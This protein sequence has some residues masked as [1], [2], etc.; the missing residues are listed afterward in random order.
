[1]TGE[2]LMLLH[3]TEGI[4]NCDYDIANPVG[5]TTGGTD[6]ARR[7][8]CTKWQ[9][10]Y[11]PATGGYVRRCAPGGFS[12]VG[13]VGSIGSLGQA[14][15]LRGTFADVKG[16]LITAGIAAGGVLLTDKVFDLFGAKLNLTGWKR[17]LAEAATGIAIGILVGK[18]LKKPRLG[19]IL[20]T[21]P[22]VFAAVRMFS[23]LMGVPA[24]SGMGSN[25]GLV[26]VMAA[27]DRRRITSPNMGVIQANPADSNF[28]RRPDYAMA[29]APPGAL[30]G[31][32]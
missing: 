20:A 11:S 21:G 3:D 17:H 13:S 8:P 1:M 29:G 22:V 10:V 24:V 12:G 4:G 18:V 2:E 23:E 30:A 14:T 9:N 6:M 5:K 26:D 7:G 16:V 19:A 27:N 15:T 31:V 28:M 32:V 25:L